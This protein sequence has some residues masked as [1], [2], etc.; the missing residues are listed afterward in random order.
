[1]QCIA[2][3]GDASYRLEMNW[4]GYPRFSD[5]G[6]GDAYSVTGPTRID[7]GQ[8]H[9]LA[10]AHDPVRSLNQLYV[11]GALVASNSANFAPSGTANDLWIGGAPDHGTARIFN[12]AIEEVAM[13]TNALSSAQVAQ[14]YTSAIPPLLITSQPRSQ[15]AGPGVSVLLTVTAAGPPPLG[16]QWQSNN[17]SLSDNLHVSGSRSAVL[18][19]ANI[20][21]DDAANYRVIVTNSAGSVTSAPAALSITAN[22][23]AWTPVAAMAPG[24]IGL[25]LLLSDGTVM[26]ASSSDGSAVGNL[27]YR[28]SPDSRGSYANGTWSS[29]ASMADTRLWFSSQVLQD[30]RVFVAGGEYGTGKSTAEVYDPLA[31]A[32]TAAPVP[33]ALLDPTKPSPIVRASV[34]Q[35]FSDSQSRLLPNGTVMLAPV[36]PNTNG[37]T[38]IYNATA[39]TWA[40]GP[41]HRSGY[42]DEASWVKLPD[43]S[44]L[45]IDPFGTNSERYIPALNQWVTDAPVPVAVYEALGGE[46]GAAFLLAD[47]R[48]FFIGGSSH[49]VFYTPSGSAAPGAWSVGPDLPGGLTAPDAAAAM[50]RNGKIL[51][52]LS[53]PLYQDDSGQNQF[54]YPISFFEFDPVSNSLTQVLGPTG[55]TDPSSLYTGLMLDLPDGGVLY[56]HFGSDLY[57]YYPAGA[58]LT[59]GKPTITS[60]SPNV[61]GSYHLVG[62]QLNGI[63]EGAA[64][65]D[66]AQMDSNYP[67]VRMTNNSN[68]NIYYARTY[69]WSSTSVMSS[70]L[71]VTTEFAVPASAPAGNY[72]L[73]VV[74][75]GISSDLAQF[76]YRVPPAVSLQP[77]SQTLALLST[78]A[79]SL[80]SSGCAPLSYQWTKNGANIGGATAS[81]FS[82]S[83][84]MVSD[85][86]NFQ[87]VVTNAY[88]AVTSSV[89]AL[90]VLKATPLITWTNPASIAAGV[91]LGPNQ[92]NATASVPGTFIY[93]PSTGAILGAGTNLLSTTFTPTDTNDYNAVTASVSIV[94][95]PANPLLLL[96]G[97]GNFG[98][99]SNA[100]GFDLS[101]NLGQTVVIERSTDLLNWLPITTGAFGSQPLYFSDPTSSNS[102]SRFYRGRIQ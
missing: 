82:I 19:I 40:A 67:L 57:I 34:N 92:L 45:T 78:T 53:T 41:T 24:E 3:K 4:Y 14:I 10:G 91:A 68:G 37:G 7:D 44:I 84:A 25:M 33:T 16:Y 97:D 20:T 9:H 23:G 101:G 94:V 8:W 69:N 21:A 59:S 98:F 49:T 55:T 15:A 32:W 52:A 80:T 26:A 30:G 72:S 50:M 35:E 102:P 71:P 2:G 85:S 27:W 6:T 11:D 70:N 18:A 74:A 77:A 83:N 54:P 76:C 42:Q 5:G 64:Y 39:N 65:G 61:D 99:R 73:V 81:S 12:G 46:L 28:L 47:G 36:G 60:I 87:V 38:L 43:D 63:S 31:D 51:C 66:D 93:S 62:T 100:F 75:N 56:S 79:F 90:T 88:A 86:G 96:A 17:V 29:L 22:A 95:Y 58:Q 48:A 13:F 1:V 89:S